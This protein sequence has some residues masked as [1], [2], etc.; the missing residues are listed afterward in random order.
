MTDRQDQDR[1]SRVACQCGNVAL[2]VTGAPILVAACYCNS[3][4]RAGHL[5]EQ[6][7]GS[8]PVVTPDGGT[9]YVLVRKDRVRI[10]EG[11]GLLEEVRLAPDSPTRRVRT[12]CCGSA[13]FVDVVKGHWLSVYRARFAR[14]APPLEMRV[15][16]KYR[17]A[18]SELARDIPNHAGRSGTFIW[19]LLAARVAMGLRVPEFAASYQRQ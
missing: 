1:V 8:P 15:M 4:Q 19:R 7:P 13:M 18:D 14:A 12:T 6:F 16:T 17:P 3:C 2:E 10:V 11:A 9:E 5:L